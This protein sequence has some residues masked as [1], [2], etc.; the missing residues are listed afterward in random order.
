[1]SIII[2]RILRKVYRGIKKVLRVMYRIARGLVVR[3]RNIKYVIKDNKYHNKVAINCLDVID[4]YKD[5]DYI[6]LYNPTWL[7]VANSTK[8]LFKNIV[9]LERVVTKKMARIISNRIIKNNI[10]QVVFSQLVDGWTDIIKQLKKFN[11]TINIKVIWHANNYEAQADYTFDLNTKLRN[12]Y[13]EKKV[14]ALAFVKHSMVEFY[15]RSGYNAFYLINNTYI[16]VKQKKK[17]LDMNNIKIGVYSADSREI[18]NIYTQIA[19]VKLIEGAMVDVVPTN[20]GAID[21]MKV[22]DIKNTYLKKYIS[23]KELMERLQSNDINI[24]AS[25]TECAPM[26]PIESFESGVMCLVGNNNDY[27]V[28]T[29]LGKYIIIEKEDDYE[30]IKNKI[31]ICLENKDKILNLYKDWKKD[32]NNQCKQNVKEFLDFKESV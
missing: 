29:E 6:V 21:Y 15:K 25:Y 17:D 1:M 4:K 22:I 10:K 24:Y 9:P 26:F 3:C 30:Y 11:K 2:R 7:G 19:A 23:T 27:F 16:D 31:M 12:L 5:Q 28:D 32:F 14:Q 8:G 18:K 20:Q 13:A